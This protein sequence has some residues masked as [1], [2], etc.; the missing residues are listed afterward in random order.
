M[1]KWLKVMSDDL[2]SRTLL[3]VVVPLTTRVRFTSSGLSTSRSPAIV[4]AVPVAI[5]TR[6]APVLAT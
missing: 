1:A 2:A 3:T 6:A 4:A 5:E